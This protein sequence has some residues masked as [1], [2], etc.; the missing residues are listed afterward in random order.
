MDLLLGQLD[1]ERRRALPRRDVDPL[2]ADSDAAGGLAEVSPA[3]GE[4][5]ELVELR[6]DLVPVR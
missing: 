5:P 4:R 6:L 1:V 3:R 2:H